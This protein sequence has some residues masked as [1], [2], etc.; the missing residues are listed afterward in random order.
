MEGSHSSHI[1]NKV[2][3]NVGILSRIYLLPRNILINLYYIPSY[4][5]IPDL[6]YNIVWASNY[7]TRLRRLVILQKRAIRV[8]AGA[9]YNAHTKQIF[10]DFKHLTNS[11][12]N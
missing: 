9:S 12:D 6:L 7:Q 4:T 10:E 11:S 8:V 5:L 2:A 3:K 1:P